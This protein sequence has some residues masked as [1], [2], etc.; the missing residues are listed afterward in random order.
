MFFSRLDG[1]SKGFLDEAAWVAAF[2]LPQTVS[3]NLVLDLS[4]AWGLLGRIASALLRARQTPTSLFQ[5]FGGNCHMN[6]PMLQQLLS[7]FDAPHGVVLQAVELLD[8]QGKGS[9]QGADFEE[10]IGGLMRAQVF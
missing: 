9:I 6:S 10:I 5:A 7:S 3:S 2:Q 1:G 8:V 4:L